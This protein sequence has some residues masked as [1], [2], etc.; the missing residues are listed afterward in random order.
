MLH[1]GPSDPR[2]HFGRVGSCGSERQDGA[3]TLPLDCLRQTDRHSSKCS[4][5]A[6]RMIP[7]FLSQMLP[8]TFQGRIFAIMPAGLYPRRRQLRRPSCMRH[9]EPARA[10]FAYV[11]S[12]R[13]RYQCGKGSSKSPVQH[14]R[15]LSLHFAGE[16]AEVA[17]SAAGKYLARMEASRISTT[18]S[19]SRFQTSSRP[20]I[21]IPIYPRSV[22]V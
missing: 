4:W 8:N 5:D 13:S 10:M 21:E 6:V 1:G 20:K 3:L 22:R 12:D 9:H 14:T 11:K 19:G 18:L 7:V 17:G 2:G 16:A 15:S